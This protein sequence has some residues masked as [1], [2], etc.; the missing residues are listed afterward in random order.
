MRSW[1]EVHEDWAQQM[2]GSDTE[3]SIIII[4]SSL[5]HSLRFMEGEGFG[6]IL[7]RTAMTNH[8]EIIATCFK[9]LNVTFLN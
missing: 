9:R 2:H 4:V 6:G 8:G 7:R 1:D 3:Y 5:H